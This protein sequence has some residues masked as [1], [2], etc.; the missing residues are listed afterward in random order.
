MISEI[1]KCQGKAPMR[2]CYCDTCMLHR[3]RRAEFLLCS[4]TQGRHD[5]YDIDKIF[6]QF[7][8]KEDMEELYGWDKLRDRIIQACRHKTMFLGRP[9]SRRV[10]DCI[11]PKLPFA[12]ASKIRFQACMYCK[13]ASR[14]PCVPC[15][16]VGLRT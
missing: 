8:K 11:D 1:G 6:K 7:I 13:I 5:T 12:P 9:M 3:T 2:A 15:V 14:V 16:S 10:E 4:V